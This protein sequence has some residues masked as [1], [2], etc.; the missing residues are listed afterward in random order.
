[1]LDNA[2]L[3]TL[4][5]KLLNEV[6]LVSEVLAEYYI[7]G[8]YFTKDE[9]ANKL[10]GK[11]GNRDVKAHIIANSYLEMIY[12][13]RE[14]SYNQQF[15]ERREINSV[16][17]FHITNSSFR[18]TAEGVIYK[19]SFFKARFKNLEDNEFTSY[20]ASDRDQNVKSMDALNLAM[21]FGIINLEIIGG[22]RPE[23]SIRINKPDKIRQIVKG[24]FDYQNKLVNEA[25]RKH[26]SDVNTLNFFFTK[27][28]SDEERWNFIEDYYLGKIADYKDRMINI[29]E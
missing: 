22:N 24:S 9:L 7:S 20:I 16:E 13:F 5:D 14:M 27:L 8:E 11:F 19:S 15:Y 4:R 2:S 1:M 29:F 18:T 3:S 26:I 23:M 17:K 28:S 10:K 25:K 6:S 21:L 12:S